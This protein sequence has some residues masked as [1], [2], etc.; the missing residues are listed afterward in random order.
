MKF[1]K[2]S[3]QLKQCQGLGLASWRGFIGTTQNLLDWSPSKQ[4]AFCYRP[5]VE[6]CPRHWPTA[7]CSAFHWYCYLLVVLLLV[8]FA[9]ANDVLVSNGEMDESIQHRMTQCIEL[10]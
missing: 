1:N 7:S 9:D 2:Y 10:V 8:T 5:K 6:T 3:R 4:R